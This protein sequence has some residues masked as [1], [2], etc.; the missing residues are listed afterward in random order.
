MNSKGTL[1]LLSLALGLFAYILFF[2]RPGGDPGSGT[3][4][5]RRLFPGLEPDKV[6][7]VEIFRSNTVIRAERTNDQ[8]RLTRPLYPAQATALNNWLALL[9]SLTQRAY[10]SAQELLAQPGGPADFGLESPVA[11][12]NVQQGARRFQFR[13]GSRTTVGDMLYL[14]EVGSDGAHVTEAALLD[15][16]PRT[17]TD[18]RDPQFL[19]L[20]GLNFDRLQVRAGEPRFEL[21]RDNATQLWRLARPRS[22]RADSGLLQ[23]V[24]RQLQTV[25]ISRFVSD[26]PGGDLEAYGLQPPALT[27]VFAQETNAVLTVELGRSPTNEPAVVFARRD[28]YPNIVTV[29]KQVLDLLRAPY[30]EFLDRRLVEF[31]PAAVHRIEVSAAEKFALEKQPGGRWQVVDPIV[32][33]ADP[34]LVSGFLQRMNSIET[35]EIIKDVASNLDLPD[36]GLAP[37]SRQYVLKTAN[38]ATPTNE[39]LAQIEFGTNQ[40]N[41]II[42]RRADE[43]SIYTTKLDESLLLPRAAFEFRERRIWTFT[44]NQVAS[45][46]ITIKGN[47][48]KVLR[49]GGGQWS[50]AP[51]SQ[52]YV[53][54]FALEEA[55]FRIGQQLRSKM[56]VARG[57][58]DLSR[59]G[60]GDATN[61]LSIELNNGAEPRT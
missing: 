26:V 53:N 13:V 51:G 54:P 43:N 25:R 17:A 59:F 46:T 27:L 24:L 19:D 45:A 36:H 8:W 3:D 52:G 28:S 31:A 2:E 20:T 23:Q 1:G 48:C 39:I 37:P 50:V 34:E 47:T 4:P 5:G 55:M 41:R 11:T 30:T 40:A 9:G 33:P 49:T 42:V 56:W 32:F 44:T 29:P 16:L 22:A 6:T 60:F 57:D 12:V 58:R 14:Q 10:I 38:G 15:R 61:K 35:V 21:Q 7:S 18:W